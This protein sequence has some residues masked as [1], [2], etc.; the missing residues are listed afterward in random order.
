MEKLFVLSMKIQ[1]IEDGEDATKII[2]ILD[3]FFFSFHYIDRTKRLEDG[4]FLYLIEIVLCNTITTTVES[5]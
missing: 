2:N 4:I 3:K 1:K 5:C